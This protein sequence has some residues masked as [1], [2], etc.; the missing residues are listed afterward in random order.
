MTEYAFELRS[1]EDADPDEVDIRVRFKAVF[2]NEDI[3]AFLA[4]FPG[5]IPISGD[6][7]ELSSIYNHHD[8]GLMSLFNDFSVYHI[9]LFKAFIVEMVSGR[10]VKF[11]QTGL[12][13]EPNHDHFKIDKCIIVS[14]DKL[15]GAYAPLFRF[16]DELAVQPLERRRQKIF[17]LKCGSFFG[18]AGKNTKDIDISYPEINT[19]TL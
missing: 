11:L 6:P 7:Y 14:R 12:L 3:N 18:C 9:S 19:T 5:T 4:R 1:L 15:T 17:G 2:A 10:L 8:G 13:S 16:N